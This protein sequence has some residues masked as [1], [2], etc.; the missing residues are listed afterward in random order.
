MPCG[1]TRSACWARRLH[2]AHNEQVC[3]LLCCA[4]KLGE[5]VE[6]HELYVKEAAAEG[7]W[8]RLQTTRDVIEQL[9]SIKTPHPLMVIE[10]LN[11]AQIE[12]RQ[13][14]PRDCGS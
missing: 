8:R 3:I 4:G 6:S 11:V 13:V 9:Q 10:R 14:C 5:F 7:L 2:L 1:D 12:V